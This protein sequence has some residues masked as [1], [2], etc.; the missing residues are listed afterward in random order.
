MM[1][2]TLLGTFF[3][4]ETLDLHGPQGQ[5]GQS[6]DFKAIALQTTPT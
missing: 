6:K 3:N 1:Y 2:K 4:K 5:Q